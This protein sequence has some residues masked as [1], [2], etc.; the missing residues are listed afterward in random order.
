MLQCRQVF[1]DSFVFSVIV[2][3]SAS[4]W[5]LY[6]SK[7]LSPVWWAKFKVKSNAAEMGDI[8]EEFSLLQKLS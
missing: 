3:L 4:E 5:H 6:A 2:P 7:W 8:Q 1:K